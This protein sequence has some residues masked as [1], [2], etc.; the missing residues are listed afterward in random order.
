MA[1]PPQ[2]S[3]IDTLALKAQIVENI[4]PHA[5]RQYDETL[6]MFFS[7][8]LSKIEFDSRCYSILGRENVRLHNQ[9]MKAIMT[10]AYRGEVPP[11]PPV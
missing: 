2:P 1:P 4:G 5:A 6:E 9:L 7:M 11:P 3:R 10:N 8:R